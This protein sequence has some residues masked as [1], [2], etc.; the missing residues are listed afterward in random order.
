[1]RTE[2]AEM[3]YLAAKR[4]TALA[5]TFALFSTEYVRDKGGTPNDLRSTLLAGETNSLALIL[6]RGVARREIDADKLTP[7]VASLLSDLFRHHVLMTWSAP[8]AD[9]RSAW[10]DTIFLPL[11][12]I[13]VE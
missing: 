6:E 10:I 12:S 1:M 13:R 3:L 8:S 7:P 11:V 9:L 2:L 4:A 5:V